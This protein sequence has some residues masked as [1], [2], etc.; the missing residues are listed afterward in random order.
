MRLAVYTY[1]LGSYDQLLDQPPAESEQT[2]YICFTDNPELTSDRWRIVLI[3]PRFPS[4]VV[5]SARFVKIVGHPELAG[6]DATL[7]IDAS[8]RLRVP[9][10]RIVDAW[11]TDGVDFAV[12]EHSYREALIDEFD[13]VIRLN[14]DDRGRV[15]EQLFD[16][17]VDHPA[18]LQ[19]R[20]LWT[21]MLARRVTNASAEMA[22]LWFDHV[23]RYSRRDQLSVLTAI[24]QSRVSV[25]TIPLDNFAS[26]LHE[27][28]VIN[29][30]RVRQGKVSPHPTG[31][32]TADLRRLA[33]ERQDIEEQLEQLDIDSAEGLRNKLH[34]LHAA[35]AD[36]HRE[37]T[38]LLDRHDQ[39]ERERGRL[40]ERLEAT[41]SVSGAWANLTRAVRA[42]VRRN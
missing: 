40:E 42:S 30:R 32:L 37:R 5:R 6:F 26:E 19:R 28:P 20:P 10:E 8:V 3:E 29:G 1:I 2:E 17:S 22:R 41:R 31:P 16:Y 38:S 33:R 13:E 23:L 24:E 35:L 11:L 4:D 34:E 39:D 12:A 7:S 15:H 14:Y 27:W 25:R 36:C 21:G 18:T 9:P